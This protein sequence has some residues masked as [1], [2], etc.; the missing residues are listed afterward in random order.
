MIAGASRGW[1]YAVSTMG[2]TGTR[3]TLDSAARRLVERL[4]HADAPEIRV[5]IG[6]SSRAQVEEVLTYA[7]GAIVG[8]AIVRALTSDGIAGVRRF[9]EELTGR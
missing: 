1:V 8:S 7:D 9:A 3:D 4:R 6:V 2:V 5:G